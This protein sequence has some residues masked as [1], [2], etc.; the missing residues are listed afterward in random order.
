LLIRDGTTF[1]ASSA[2]TG[3]RLCI[4][5]ERL[6]VGNSVVL[7]DGDLFDFGDGQIRFR[8]FQPESA[9]PVA[10]LIADPAT[11]PRDASHSRLDRIILTASEV[12][13]GRASHAHWTLPDLP[14]EELRLTFGRECGTAAVSDGIVWWD[15]SH[16]SES[17]QLHIEPDLSEAELLSRGLLGGAVNGIVISLQGGPLSNA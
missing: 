2:W 14:C 11:A 9:E 8:F 6:G 10:V 13:A 1:R 16:D 5:G 17:G 4:N 7:C 15:A 12:R 3:S